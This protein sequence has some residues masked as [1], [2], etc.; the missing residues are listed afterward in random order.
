MTEQ[1]TQYIKN[2]V[3]WLK[4]K[5][6]IHSYEKRPPYFNEGEIWW[7][8][9]GENIGDEENGKGSNFLR[10]VIVITKF[11]KNICL[12]VPTSTKIKDNQ[13]Y[14]PISYKDQNYSALVSQIRTVDTKRFKKKIAQLSAPDLQNIR[15]YLAKI[16]LKQK[17]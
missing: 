14:Y 12:V 8:Q 15:Q 2:F 13:Y 3:D 11:N 1:L 10:P 5:S 9:L 16:L 4:L 6:D 7:C 17:N